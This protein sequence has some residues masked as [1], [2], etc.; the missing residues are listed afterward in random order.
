MKFKY[1]NKKIG[2]PLH[3]FYTEE[4]FELPKILGEKNYVIPFKLL[5]IFDLVRTFAINSYKLISDYIH[6]LEQEQ[7]DEH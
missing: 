1:Y 2:E 6:L 5:K 4:T 7:F 3:C